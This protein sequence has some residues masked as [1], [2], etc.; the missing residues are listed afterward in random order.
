MAKSLYP[1][2][3][4]I[5]V[6]ELA[7]LRKA[8]LDLRLEFTN[9]LSSDIARSAARGLVDWFEF[10]VRDGEEF[11]RLIHPAKVI[12]SRLRERSLTPVLKSRSNT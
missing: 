9:W 12:R 2:K 3:E 5:Q 10:G 6:E 11:G 4:S 8:L 7:V 1:L